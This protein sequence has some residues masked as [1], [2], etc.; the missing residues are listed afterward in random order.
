M[1]GVSEVFLKEILLVSVSIDP[2]DTKMLQQHDHE[3]HEISVIQS[4]SISQ[5][6]VSLRPL[7]GGP[8]LSLQSG[9][10]IVRSNGNLD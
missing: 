2:A 5:P 4:Y 10:L 3:D 6:P 1:K 9:Q 7:H 8:Y